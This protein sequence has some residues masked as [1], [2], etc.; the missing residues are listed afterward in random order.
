MVTL[1]EVKTVSCDDA[2]IDKNFEYLRRLSG[3]LSAI[4]LLQGRLIEDQVLTGGTDMT[5]FHLLGRRLKG[6]LPVRVSADT[7]IYDKQST[8]GDQGSTLVLRSVNTVT[9]SLWVF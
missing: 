1:Q 8:N 7:R 6:W 3:E 5:I 4:L 9:V 2:R